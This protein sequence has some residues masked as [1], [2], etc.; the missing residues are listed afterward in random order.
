VLPESEGRGRV[1]GLSSTAEGATL[2]LFDSIVNFL[3]GAP[4]VKPFVLILDN[5][6]WADRPSLLLLEF[7]AQALQRGRLLVAGTYR[8][9]E[10]FDEHPLTHTLDE[11]TKEPHFQRVP[12]R[13]LSQSDVKELIERLAGFTPAKT[14]V[15]SV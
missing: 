4:Q 9:E 5:L 8:D 10:V 3:E 6:R 12:L 11:Q 13:G 7:L 14:L 1:F 2:R 15:G